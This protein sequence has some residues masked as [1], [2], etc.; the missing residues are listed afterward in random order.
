[1]LYIYMWFVI[2]FDYG[3]YVFYDACMLKMISLFVY[4]LLSF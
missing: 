3:V 4:G 2:V 1:M